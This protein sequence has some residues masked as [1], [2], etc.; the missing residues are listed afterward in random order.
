[1]G[2]AVLQKLSPEEIYKEMN[3]LKV[4]EEWMVDELVYREMSGPLGNWVDFKTESFEAGKDITAE[5]LESLVDEI[6][7]DLLYW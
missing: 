1:M 3:S 4:A 2:M 6:V 7:A 5:L